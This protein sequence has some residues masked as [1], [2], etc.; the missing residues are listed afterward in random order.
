[1]KPRYI[2][3][4][5]DLHLEQYQG[6]RAEF[7]RN[8]F[9][10][11]DDRDA[12][13]ILVLAGD[14]SSKTAQLVEFLREVEQYFLRVYYL[15][16]NHE[17]YGHNMLKWSEHMLTAMKEGPAGDPANPKTAIVTLDVGVEELE[18]V[19][20]IWGTLW[21]DGDKSLADQAAIARGLRDFY[22]IMM[23]DSKRNNPPRRFTVQDMMKLCQEH[24]RVIKEH[25]AKPFDGVTVVA[26]HHL[27]SYRLCHPRFGTDING[28]FAA[29]CDD[30][31]AYDNAPDVW[32]HGHTHDTGDG[33]MWNTRIVCNPS[34]YYFEN[35]ARYKN[36]KPFFIDLE[37]PKNEKFL[38]IE[39]PKIDLATV[40]QILAEKFK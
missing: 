29:N 10:P 25:L 1:M 38:E 11:H 33:V 26:T 27:P 40:R 7:L 39:Q 32:I 18:N 9:V 4:C 37:N 14:I 34:G 16:G 2:R 23:D 17:F 35:D 31:L 15:P 6:Q 5:S 13:S 21:G 20:I 19:R 30:I 36:F 12:E 24:K 28:G 22:V 3:V 8:N